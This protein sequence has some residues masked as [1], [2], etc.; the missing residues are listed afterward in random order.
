MLRPVLGEED[1]SGVLVS[2]FSYLEPNSTLAPPQRSFSPV[3]V[4][5]GQPSYL[6]EIWTD[7]EIFNVIHRMGPV[8][9]DYTTL[10]DSTTS[11]TFRHSN[12]KLSQYTVEH[13]L[14]FHG[15]WIVV[16]RDSALRREIIHS[17]HD[18]KLA[19][20]PGRVP[21]QP[22]ATLLEMAVN[23]TAC[24]LKPLGLLRGPFL[25]LPGKCHK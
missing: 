14:L 7:A 12:P 6:W 8:D 5:A 22:S 4:S 17:H 20:H 19:E 21:S 16:P 15:H 1:G 25:A 13:G 24:E 2:G 11:P 18:S 10:M 3:P 23:P 9:Q